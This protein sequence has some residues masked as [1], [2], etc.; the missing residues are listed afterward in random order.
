MALADKHDRHPQLVPVSD[1]MNAAFA[2]VARR[3]GVNPFELERE[4][5]RLDRG[6]DALVGAMLNAYD[7][8]R[9]EKK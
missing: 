3:F 5:A 4:R 8:T 2:Q 1:A 7:R 9:G 6:M